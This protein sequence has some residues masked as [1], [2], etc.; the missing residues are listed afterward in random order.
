M[1]EIPF[2]CRYAA[3]AFYAEE[4]RQ[5]ALQREALRKTSAEGE[6]RIMHTSR[7]ASVSTL[8]AFAA[9]VLTADIPRGPIR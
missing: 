8:A 9:L 1:R 5:L 2:R 3:D 4:R 6:R 7:R